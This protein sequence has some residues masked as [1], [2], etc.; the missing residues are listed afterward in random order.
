MQQWGVLLERR[1]VQHDGHVHIGA[2]DKDSVTY[3]CFRATNCIVAVYGN[4]QKCL[5]SLTPIAEALD[6]LESTANP[7]KLA[8]ALS[9]ALPPT[10]DP[11]FASICWR[12]CSRCHWH[13]YLEN[14]NLVV[15][16]RST[17]MCP[18]SLYTYDGFLQCLIF[19]TTISVGGGYLYLGT[20]GSNLQIKYGTANLA[21]FLAKMM[22]TIAHE[23]CEPLFISCGMPVMGPSFQ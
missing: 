14:E 2:H 5:T 4:M 20:G 11:S 22:D 8:S 18:S 12:P 15:K 9:L 17:V 1:D 23:L 7:T 21:L 13:R 10:I 16:L 19:Y 3:Y 6:G